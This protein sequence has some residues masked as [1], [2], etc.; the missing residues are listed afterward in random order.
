MFYA[1]ASTVYL[2]K[3]EISRVDQCKYLDIMISTK[4]CTIDMKRQMTKFYSKINILSRIFSKCSSDVKCMVF[5]SFCSNIYCSTMWYNCTFSAM[6]KLR[7]SYNN[8]LRQLLSIAN[9]NS[10]EINVNLK[11]KSFGEL[12]IKSHLQSYEQTTVFKEHTIIF[13]M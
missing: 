8:S 6:R 7:I 9:N 2:N 1:E 5:K 3:L 10:S 13:Y 12:I 4:N 11:I